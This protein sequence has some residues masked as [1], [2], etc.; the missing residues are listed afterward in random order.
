MK[1]NIL[2]LSS[3]VVIPLELDA[4][5]SFRPFIDYL[6]K[7]VAG[8][9]TAKAGIYTKALELFDQYNIREKDISLEEVNQY[10]ELLELLY[11]CLSPP[12]ADEGDLAWGLSFPF[13]PQVFYGTELLF[14]LLE[15]KVGEHDREKDPKSPEAYHKDRLQ[16]LYSFILQRLYNLRMSVKTE[17]YHAGVHP[18]TGLL[19]YYQVHINTDFLDV[20]PV[21]PLPEPNFGDISLLMADDTGYEA[22]EKILP[23]SAFR[24]RGIC[25]LSISDVTVQKAVDNIEN[26]RLARTPDND[27]SSYRNVI[28]SLKT[29]VG[30]Q[31]IEFDLFPLVKINNE[32]VYGYKKA[33][34]GILFE[35]WGDRLSPDVFRKQAKGYFSHPNS[36]FSRDLFGPKEMEISFLEHFRKLKVR[37]L[38]LLPVFYNR[39]PVG[40]LAMHTWE[41]ETFEETTVSLLEPALPAIA[42][43]FEVYIDEFNLE[44]ETI[45]KEKFTSIQPSVQ[46]KFNEI[47]WHYLRDRKKGLPEVAETIQFNEVYPLYGAVDIRNSTIERNKAIIS[48][49]DTHLELLMTT[50]KTLQTEHYTVL[51]EEM[52]YKCGKWKEVLGQQQ[53]NGNDENKLVGFFREETTPYLQHIS[54]QNG[55]SLI[56][57]EYLTALEKF[58]SNLHGSKHALEMSMQTINTVVNNYFEAQKDQLQS[59]YP[60]YFEKFRT[61]G[62]EY[63]IYIGQ[64]FAPDKP[65]NHFHLKNLRLWQLSS[66][67]A[68]AQ[69]TASL[70]PEMAVPLRT[71]QLI[72]VHNHTIDISFRADERKFDVEGAYNIRYQMIK[73]RIDKVHLRNSEER[74]TQ[75]DKIVLIY[76]DNK[77]IEDYLPFIQYLQEKGTLNNDLEELD[78]EDL[79]GL[80]GLKA[81]RVGVAQL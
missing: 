15:S 32:P 79:Q 2:D 48:D 44:I 80:S 10:P 58:N 56:L 70:V 41:D 74:L 6:R 12:L 60:C 63:D 23:L 78:L 46:W 47:A 3:E 21:G 1:N 8:E 76:F 38:A 64:S 77:D 30:N 27:E 36:F 25:V 40:V 69:L 81:L 4:A 18:E 34:T 26:V 33:G 7:R 57:Q 52:I 9:R 54:K 39:Q 49:L 37:S 71:T 51:Q 50:L 66:M 67:A 35:V 53:L 73:K 11:V 62:V 22:F 13:Q 68:V 5:I 17:Q 24:F 65:F 55:N 61:D 59:S 42:Q 31:K 45:I 28:N 29:I 20:E 19:Q 16:L 43:L 14:Q 72:F 75:P